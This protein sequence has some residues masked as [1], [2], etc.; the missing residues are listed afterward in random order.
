MS[1]IVLIDSGP[2]GLATNPN[3]TQ[4]G[5]ACK[6]WISNLPLAGHL[7]LVPAVID[8][9]L[10]RELQLMNRQ[11]ALQTLDRL[12]QLG[13]LPLTGDA[14]LK[15]ADFWAVARRGGMPAADRL[16]L[17]A[18]VILAGQAATLDPSALEMT[19]AAGVVATENL[20]HLSRFVG[21]RRW[22]DIS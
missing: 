6:E 12:K 18:D 1:L 21:A 2:L 14:L 3:A 11:R 5:L 20:G 22:Q 9:E 8:Y 19:G 7:L 17:D 4:D 13:Y 10:R 16:A 15:A